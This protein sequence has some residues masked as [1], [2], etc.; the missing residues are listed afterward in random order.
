MKREDVPDASRDGAIAF[1]EQDIECKHQDN[2]AIMTDV[3]PVERYQDM[4]R[5]E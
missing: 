2:T 3:Q 1:R 4:Q 5:G